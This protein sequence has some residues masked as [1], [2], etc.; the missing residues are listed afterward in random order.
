MRLLTIAILLLALVV[1]A[2]PAEACGGVGASFGL[3]YG[4]QFAPS[5]NTGCGVGAGLGLGY[6]VQQQFVPVPVYTGGGLGSGVIIN[7]NVV[8]RRFVGNRAFLPGRSFI[9]GRGIFGRPR[10]GFGLGFSF[11]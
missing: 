4:A 3:G 5:Y 7:N 2:V 8:N 6:G 10:V 1:F 11:R 9:P